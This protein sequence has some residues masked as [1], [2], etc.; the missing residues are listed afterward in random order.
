[1]AALGVTPAYA[2]GGTIYTAKHGDTL[3][4]I[5]RQYGVSVT[6][7]AQANGLTTH[8]WVTVGQRLVIP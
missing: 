4:G 5:A 7:L 3:Y 6:A 8:S 2:E 1:V